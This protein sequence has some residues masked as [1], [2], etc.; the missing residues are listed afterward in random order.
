MKKQKRAE[1]SEHSLHSELAKDW[2]KN[3]R[4][5]ARDGSP[6]YVLNKF[7]P[8]YWNRSRLPTTLEDRKK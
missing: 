5:E 7:L 2:H 4:A 1:D 6:L 8:S 3:F